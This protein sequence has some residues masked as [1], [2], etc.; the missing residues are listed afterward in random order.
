LSQR[1]PSAGSFIL[2]NAF[3]SIGIFGISVVFLINAAAP[4]GD[5]GNLQR[6]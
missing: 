3:Y 6:L 4:M 2:A 5:A 1:I